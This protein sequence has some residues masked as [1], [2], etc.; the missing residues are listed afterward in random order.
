MKNYL[1]PIAGGFFVL[2]WIAYFVIEPLDHQFGNVGFFLLI[3]LSLC[4]TGAWLVF[5]CRWNLV[6]RLAILSTPFLLIAFLISQYEFRGFSGE[7]IPQFRMRRIAKSRD[8]PRPLEANPPVSG[9]RRENADEESSIADDNTANQNANLSNAKTDV[10]QGGFH[11]FLGNQRNGIIANIRIADDWSSSK[12]EIVW[13]VPIGEGWSGFAVDGALAITQ[14]QT[15]RVES[16]TAFE[17]KTGQRVWSK[18]LSRRHSH[19]LGGIGPRATPTIEN[20]KAYVQSATGVVIC[21]DMKQGDLNWSVD[22]LELAGV[23]QKEAEVAVTWGRSGSPLIYGD[24]LIVPFGGGKGKPVNGLIALD[25]NTGAELWRGGSDQISYASPSIAYLM[26]REQIVIV[27]ESTVTGHDPQDGTTLWS[28]PWE[29]SSAGGASVSQ[30]VQIDEATIFLSKG[31]GGGCALLDMTHSLDEPSKIVPVWSHRNLMKTKFTNAIVYQDHLYGLSDGILECL[32]V[33]DGKQ[34]WKANRSGRFG[35]GQMLI[36]GNHILVSTEDGRCVV[37]KASPE[38]ATIVGEL[39]VLDG[40]T[41][42]IPSVFGDV[43]LMRNA[44]EAACIRLPVIA[45]PIVGEAVSGKAATDKL[46][47]E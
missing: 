41:W 38:A 26:K 31:Y 36:V 42:N 6:V 13:K 17:W 28:Y 25:K 14:E 27:N 22:L 32:R 47:T 37:L 3:L 44:E 7:L 4:F 10:A 5:R 46:S 23:N 2:A 21:L 16:V 9:D 29:G 1:L 45:Q 24:S 8:V 30:A 11:Q 19:P 35:H 18:Q 40:I 34:M 33:K 12:P 39:Q 20:G 15:D 43:V